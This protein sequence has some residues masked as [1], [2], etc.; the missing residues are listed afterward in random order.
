MKKLHCAPPLLA[1]SSSVCSVFLFATLSLGCSSKSDNSDGA[2]GEGGDDGGG[3]GGGG[4]GGAAGEGSG[5]GGGS[6]GKGGV[7]GS[8]GNNGGTGG[9]AGSGGTAGGSGGGAG[10]AGG[11]TFGNPLE[12]NP[13]AAKVEGRMGF[14]SEGPLWIADGG[15]LLFSD[16][17]N[18][19][20]WKLEPEKPAAMRFTEFTNYKA[21]TR[22]N[23]LALD[24]AGNL[25]VCERHTGKVGKMKLPSGDKSFLADKFNNQPFRAPNDIVS[26]KNGNT[27]FTDPE[28]CSNSAANPCS[29]ST[30][31][32]G[33]YR[34]DKAGTVHLITTGAEKPQN[35][36]GIALSP[37]ERTLYIGDDKGKKVWKYAV[38]AE[39]ATGAGSEFILN[40]NVPDGIAIDNAGNIYV[41]DQGA[42][43]ILVYKPDGTKLGDIK[44]ENSP[45]NASFGGSDFKT[46]F[47]TAKPFIYSVK[48][49]VP[50]IP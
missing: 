22:T 19:K 23:G 24:T 14:D 32:V 40:L 38:T 33:A 8:G 42:K 41:A 49:S 34:V 2:G 12:G 27:Y 35:P 37:D 4:E 39:G 47:I 1:I 17:D 45:S 18:A 7:G 44:V 9:A 28:W 25:L 48:L 13:Q 36:N 21:N 43:A 26:G 31:P 16:V 5:G 46:L 15:Y 30:L 6:G 29:G 20:I 3:E 50:G 11:A 10:G